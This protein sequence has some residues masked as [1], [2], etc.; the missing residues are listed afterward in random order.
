MWKAC[1][2]IVKLYLGVCNPFNLLSFLG[3]TTFNNPNWCRRY[4]YYRRLCSLPPVNW[5][6]NLGLDEW[7]QLNHLRKWLK[8][9]FF[10]LNEK[11]W[12]WRCTPFGW[13]MKPQGS[14][15][16]IKNKFETA[17]F[18]RGKPAVKLRGFV[19]SESLPSQ[20]SSP[21]TRGT[22]AGRDIL[23]ITSNAQFR[24]PMCSSGIHPF[25]RMKK[26]MEP[27]NTSE[28]KRRNIYKPNCFEK[29][30]QKVVHYEY[31]H[32][33]LRCLVYIYPW[34]CSWLLVVYNL[35]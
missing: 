8:T 15:V 22:R 17:R 5:T 29:K 3:S 20:R 27:E 33:F 23:L 26:H 24:R 4:N 6:R 13:A 9:S 14:G 12:D 34:S 7:W 1:S 10:M 19:S 2:V 31:D 16:N 35:I 32:V 25:K 21:A 30:S 11:R 28:M 18:F